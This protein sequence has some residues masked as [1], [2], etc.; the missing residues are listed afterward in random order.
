MYRYGDSLFVCYKELYKVFATANSHHGG[1]GSIRGSCGVYGGQSGN[2]TGFIPSTS[3]FP[4][5]YRGP[6]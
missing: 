5:Q 3:V 2:G 6:G 4:C 1:L